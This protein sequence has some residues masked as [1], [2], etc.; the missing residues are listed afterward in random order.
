DP[1]GGMRVDQVVGQQGLERG[2]VF[3]AHRLHALAIEIDDRFCVACHVTPPNTQLEESTDA[4]ARRCYAAARGRQW[5]WGESSWGSARRVRPPSSI[6][7][8]AE[9]AA[10]SMSWGAAEKSNGETASGHKVGTR[11]T[12]MSEEITSSSCMSCQ[13]ISK[14]TACS[15]LAT[16]RRGGSASAQA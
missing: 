15:A 6:H 1:G 16:A 14:V 10:R 9:A 8:C 13:A 3:L 11:C 5:R 2:E 7:F 12:S 4:C